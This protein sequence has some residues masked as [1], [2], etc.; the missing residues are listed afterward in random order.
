MNPSSMPVP[1]DG[2]SGL[3][4]P[5]LATKVGRPP[6]D[7]AEPDALPPVPAAGETAAGAAPLEEVV[8]AVVHAA[9]STRG[10]KAA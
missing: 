1:L 4:P 6:A 8:V 10:R 7:D 2:R 5:V 3:G 9:L